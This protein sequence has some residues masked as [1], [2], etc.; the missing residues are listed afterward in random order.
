MAIGYK[1]SHAA[2][3]LKGAQK[4]EAYKARKSLSKGVKREGSSGSR[5]KSKK[6]LKITNHAP[7]PD[8]TRKDTSKRKNGYSIS[9]Q[10]K[11]IKSNSDAVHNDMNYLNES[12]GEGSSHVYANRKTKR[13]KQSEMVLPIHNDSAERNALLFNSEFN[14][15]KYAQSPFLNKLTSL[16]QLKMSGKKRSNPG[17]NKGHKSRNSMFP[18]SYTEVN[19]T[20][21]RESEIYGQFHSNNFG[22]IVEE[23]ILKRPED[24]KI[25]NPYM[26]IDVENEVISAYGNDHS[27]SNNRATPQQNNDNN[28]ANKKFKFDSDKKRAVSVRLNLPKY[29]LFR[30]QLGLKQEL[31]HQMT[32]LI[33]IVDICR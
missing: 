17:L 26:N 25:S 1:Q 18:K 33:Q 20:P 21:R 22:K 28:E 32:Q 10:N 8:L 5:S 16:K 29:I 27:T 23:D 19:E 30:T 3:K 15:V 31:M 6:L 9:K 12:Q 7:Y 4:L 11:H 2:A 14:T 24:S 13:K